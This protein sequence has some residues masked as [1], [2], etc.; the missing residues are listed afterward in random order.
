MTETHHILIQDRDVDF[1][2]GHDQ[3][4]PLLHPSSA[5]TNFCSGITDVPTRQRLLN[6]IVQ[7]LYTSTANR[8]VVLVGEHGGFDR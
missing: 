2:D 3:L 1:G 4:R 5:V 6:V 7:S 8:S